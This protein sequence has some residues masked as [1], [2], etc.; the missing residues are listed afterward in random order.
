MLADNKTGNNELA[1][2]QINIAAKLN[3]LHL[4][5]GCFKSFNRTRN[6]NKAISD[7]QLI[8]GY[9]SLNCKLNLI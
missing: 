9:C 6:V 8:K 3:C 1:I 2:N 4:I 5:S 7:L